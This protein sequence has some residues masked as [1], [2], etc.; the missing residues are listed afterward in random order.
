[1]SL[2]S[3]LR[4][5]GQAKTGVLSG[6]VSEMRSTTVRSPLLELELFVRFK[7]YPPQGAPL[8][9]PLGTSSLCSHAPQTRLREYIVE[10]QHVVREVL[11]IRTYTQATVFKFERARLWTKKIHG[12]REFSVH[13][14]AVLCGM[15]RRTERNNATHY[16]SPSS[17]VDASAP[18]SRRITLG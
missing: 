14:N 16:R 4:N 15:M 13:A 11:L 2:D 8:Y 5:P 9:G 1:M 17:A 12:H 7:T 18:A 3:D 6:R 10:Y